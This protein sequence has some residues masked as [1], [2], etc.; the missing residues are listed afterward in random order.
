MHFDGTVTLG[1]LLVMVTFAIAAITF[2]LKLA[3]DVKYLK[4][5]V[6]AHAECNER[7][8]KV[9]EEVRLELAYRRGQ[10]DGES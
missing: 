2:G 7:Q 8:I 3:H 10:S 1:N 6:A 9:L 5:W 4:Q